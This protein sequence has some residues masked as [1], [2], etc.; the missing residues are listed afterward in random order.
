MK[1]PDRYTLDND[2]EQARAR[3]DVLARRYDPHTRDCLE[4]AGLAPGMRCLE[5]GGGGGSVAAWTAERVGPTGSVLATDIN[6]HRMQSLPDIDN[7][8]VLR[9]DIVRDELPRG[10]FDLVHARLVLLH[11]AER[12]TALANMVAALR[13]GGRL[14]VEDFDCSRI[15][16][17]R[18]PNADAISLFRAVHAALMDVIADHGADP[19][20]AERAGAA[21]AEAG[22]VDLDTDTFSEPWP[23]GEEGITLHRAN[24]AQLAEEIQA[25]GV[26][27]DDLK[28]FWDLLDDPAFEIG[29]YPLVSCWGRLPGGPA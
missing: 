10:H 29:S 13:P 22:L 25:A 28:R 20:W 2:A 19:V 23:G 17:R 27:E 8:T 4:R 24:T 14:L 15:P 26:A 5:V 18:A 16:I 3:F 1:A 21:L 9:H 12:R 11:V 6:P 7:L